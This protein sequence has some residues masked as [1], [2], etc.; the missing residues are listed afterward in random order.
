MDPV[1]GDSPCGEYGSLETLRLPSSSCP[2]SSCS[3]AFLS[4][5]SSLSI[6]L[7]L[8]IYVA[9]ASVPF[10]FITFALIE[11]AAS[12]IRSSVPPFSRSFQLRQ[13]LGRKPWPPHSSSLSKPIPHL[14]DAF[15]VRPR[16]HLC[17]Y[18]WARCC[19]EHRSQLCEPGHK[20]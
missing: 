10:H 17:V 5:L 12:L 8:I 4:S 20:K 13:L 7:T 1:L 9:F 16:F 11:I 6:L 14:Q 15:S 2:A 3:P 18:S 19:P